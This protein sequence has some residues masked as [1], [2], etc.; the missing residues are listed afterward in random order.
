MRVTLDKLEKLSSRKREFKPYSNF[1]M[2]LRDL[3]IV[4]PKEVKQGEI[5]EAIRASAPNGMLRSLRLYDL[6]KF[7]EKDSDKISYTYALAF[8]SDEKTLTNEEVNSVQDKIIKN[9]SKKL[10]AEL[11]K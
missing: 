4:V 8:Q 3:S 6:Y 9:L 2:V 1:P 10:N 11:R 5:E 7:G